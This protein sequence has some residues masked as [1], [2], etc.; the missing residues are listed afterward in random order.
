[1]KYI[2]V[3]LDNIYLTADSISEELFA[4]PKADGK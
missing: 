4:K 3:T 1:M 2:C